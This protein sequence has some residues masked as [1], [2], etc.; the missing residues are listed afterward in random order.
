MRPW[1]LALDASTIT[2]ACRALASRGD[3]DCL[4]LAIPADQSGPFHI[5]PC[6]SVRDRI[7]TVAPH[8]SAA[9]IPITP[10]FSQALLDNKPLDWTKARMAAFAWPLVYDH[11]QERTAIDTRGK[12]VDK[13]SGKSAD[14]ASGKL[15]LNTIPIGNRIGTLDVSNYRFGSPQQSRPATRSNLD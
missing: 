3:V 2:A 13:A 15:A 11:R 8:Q 12:L 1:N 4:C 14:E 5:I 10:A 6:E 9:C 7:V